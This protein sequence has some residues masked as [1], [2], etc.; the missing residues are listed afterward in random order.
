MSRERGKQLTKA[1]KAE[2]SE[3]ALVMSIKGHPVVKIAEELEVAWNTANALVKFAL[4][5]RD[6]D[7]DA[8]RERSLAHHRGI[9][10]WCWQQL[11]DEELG[12]FAQNRPAYVARIQHSQ[13]EIDRLNNVTPPVRMEQNVNVSYRDYTTGSELEELFEEIDGWLAQEDGEADSPLALDTEQAD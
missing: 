6:I 10:E 11:E 2:L 13:A 9:I 8:E 4:K 1:E 12:K 7:E 5:K 3:K